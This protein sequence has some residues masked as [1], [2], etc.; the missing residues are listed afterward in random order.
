MLDPGSNKIVTEIPTGVS[1]HFVNYPRGSTLGIVVV[2]GPGELLLF[3]PATHKPARTITVG[4][5]PNWAAT[6][7]DGKTAYVTNEGSNDLTVVDLATARTATIT[8]GNAPRR[9]VVRPGA[10]AAGR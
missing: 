7:S 1:P 5:Q 2:Q 9:V 3:D 6:S 10:A 4:K 8:V